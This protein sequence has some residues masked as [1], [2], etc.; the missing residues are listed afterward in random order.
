M[1]T[2]TTAEEEQNVAAAA[3]AGGWSVARPP[4]DRWAYR[5][6][7]PLPRRA[8]ASTDPDSVLNTFSP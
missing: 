4:L 5:S 8:G 1:T 6:P 3:A 2:E 7:P